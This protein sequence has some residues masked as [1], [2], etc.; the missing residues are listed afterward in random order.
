MSIGTH[1]YDVIAV[2][3][4][5]LA[6]MPLRTSHA[7]DRSFQPIECGSRVTRPEKNLQTTHVAR[8]DRSLGLCLAVDQRN[9]GESTASRP[10]LAGFRT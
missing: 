8:A 2:Q 9:V 3:Y 10:K 1:N 4:H 7:A 6:I 5:D